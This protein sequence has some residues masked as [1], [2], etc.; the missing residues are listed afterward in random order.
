MGLEILL[1]DT[2]ETFYWVGFILADGYI[3]KNNRLKIRIAEKDLLHLKKF[4]IFVDENVIIYNNQA[5]LIVQNKKIISPFKEKFEISNRKT[6]E[7]PSINIFLNFDSKLLLS[8]IIGFIDGD[9]S[10]TYQYNRTDALLRI[11]NHKSWLE[12]LTFFH[13]I[14]SHE[15]NIDFPSPK[16]NNQGYSSLICSNLKI[17]QYLKQHTIEYHLPVLKRKW[18]KIDINRISRCDSAESNKIEIL[19]LNEMGYK[20][21]E[22]AKIMNLSRSRVSVILSNDRKKIANERNY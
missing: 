14:I 17:L 21:R 12:I 9:G 22:I 13:K 1:E 15:S 20:Q 5:C 11:K 2:H 7:P 19:K 3:T 18:D 6:Y 10:I 8:L 4:G 16:I